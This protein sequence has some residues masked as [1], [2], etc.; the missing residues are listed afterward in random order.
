MKPPHA[1]APVL[2]ALR[3][4]ILCLLVCAASPCPAQ[5]MQAQIA[6]LDQRIYDNKAKIQQLLREKEQALEEMRRGLFCSECRRSKREIERTGENFE[7]HLRD[8]KGQ[9]I[10]SPGALA[11]KAAF[12]D[13]QIA[14]LQN[15]IN[16]LERMKTSLADAASRQADMERQ[17]ADAERARQQRA[18]QLVAERKQMEQLKAQLN[19][20]QRET[21]RV[22]RK[23]DT[24]AESNRRAAQDVKN[25]FKNLEEQ[26]Q[27]KF[28]RER[29][30]R[31]AERAE[32][33]AREEQRRYDR[34][35][36]A[37]ERKLEAQQEKIAQLEREE[38]TA[39]GRV[40]GGGSFELPPPVQ[41]YEPPGEAQIARGET[42]VPPLDDS[43]ARRQ[44]EMDEEHRR[45][46]AELERRERERRV[47]DSLSS[48]V[49]GSAS[50]PSPA[51]KLRGQMD[52]AGQSLADYLRENVQ[53]AVERYQGYSQSAA[54][55]LREF[56]RSPLFNNYLEDRGLD[57]LQGKE[58]EPINKLAKKGV[59]TVVD[60]VLLEKYSQARFG[61]RYDQLDLSEQILVDQF[62]KWPVDAMRQ[63]DPWT[64][65][66]KWNRG[67]MDEF[68]KYLDQ[69]VDQIE[70]DLERK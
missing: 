66:Y 17:R 55:K 61:K 26:F 10:A 68:K 43:L 51:E 8:V 58:P 57:L 23:A 24:I 21:E 13:R 15:Q 33:E 32:K 65:I 44:R 50:S 11:D 49:D 42:R 53:P 4:L 1:S 9:A 27:R 16:D 45:N 29:L 3:A 64:G 52:A 36:E 22:V 20:R 63:T 48:L 31:E 70:R 25:T 54:D 30:E 5:D 69:Y 41:I 28:E 6:R 34:E 40:A 56:G 14:A 60:S 47:F 38:A 18:S 46:V 19:Q 7:R 59:E 67:R 12:Y 39:P 62:V 37:F 2:L 35:V